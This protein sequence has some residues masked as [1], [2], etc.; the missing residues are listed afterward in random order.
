MGSTEI[1]QEIHLSQN[2]D[3]SYLLSFSVDT[4]FHETAAHLLLGCAADVLK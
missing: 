2:R 3:G 1:A 4:I